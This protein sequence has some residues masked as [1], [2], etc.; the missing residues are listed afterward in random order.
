MV[1]IP[2]SIINESAKI[3]ESKGT[4]LMPLNVEL[5]NNSS[6]PVRVFGNAALSKKEQMIPSV[7]DYSWE[8]AFYGVENPSGLTDTRYDI[9]VSVAGRQVSNSDL[10][11]EV[12]MQRGAFNCA[13]LVTPPP[14]RSTSATGDQAITV[15]REIVASAGKPITIISDLTNHI[16]IDKDNIQK[17]WIMSVRGKST[18]L[19]GSG[20]FPRVTASFK[21]KKPDGSTFSYDPPWVPL[22]LKKSTIGGSCQ[23]ELALPSKPAIEGALVQDVSITFSVQPEGPA[24]SNLNRSAEGTSVKFVDLDAKLLELPNNPLAIGLKVF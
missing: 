24:Y 21:Y 2:E 4:D 13:L 19:N 9:K 17:L 7:S 20:G 6:E 11:S 14:V 3:A 8:K 12:G 23:F 18:L 10:S 1:R 5:A 22:H 15:P 16:N